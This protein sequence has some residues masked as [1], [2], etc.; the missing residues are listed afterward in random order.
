MKASV[1][2]VADALTA[3]GIAPEIT[4]FAESTRTA[5]EAAQAVGATVGQ[6][7]K[8]LVFSSEDGPLLVLAS[9]A[10]R[11]DM[12]KLAQVV[13]GPVSR[14]NADLVRSATGYS[15]GGVPPVGHTRSLRTLF[16][17]DLLQ[18]D[19]VWAAA[20][21]PNAVFPLAPERLREIAG[22]EVADIGEQA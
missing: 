6:I 7:V 14:A 11:V 4:E 15:I 12:T 10:H 13:G 21:T 9:G 18:Y 16:D 8:S 20:G 2:K 19:V 22:G 1:Q 3:L 5:D 17:R